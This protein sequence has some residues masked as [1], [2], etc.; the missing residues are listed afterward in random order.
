MNDN[1]SMTSSP[2]KRRRQFRN[3][4]FSRVYAD[5][6]AYNP[7]KKS[8]YVFTHEY[9]L[10]IRR[11]QTGQPGTIRLI[12]EKRSMKEDSREAR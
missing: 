12:F 8:L 2:L 5:N 9:V 10:V 3:G 1:I 11:D 4:S 6:T 7:E